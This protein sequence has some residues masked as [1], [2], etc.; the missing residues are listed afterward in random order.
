MYPSGQ[1]GP[2]QEKTC[3]SV[4]LGI[5]TYG[6]TGRPGAWG[7]HILSHGACRLPPS[8]GKNIPCFQ[9]YLTGQAYNTI[10]MGKN[11]KILHVGV[12]LA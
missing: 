8:S 9:I 11:I 10:L 3:Q 5:G 1:L 6:S 12:S 2:G 7:H 4:V